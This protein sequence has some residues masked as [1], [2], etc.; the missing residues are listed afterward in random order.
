MGINFRFNAK[1]LYRSFLLPAT[2]LTVAFAALLLGG[3]QRPSVERA[4]S[5]QSPSARDKIALPKAAQ[6]PEAEIYVDEAMR[7]PPMAVIG[8]TIQN[9]AAR[10]LDDL[11]VEI[12]LTRRKD[13]S[14]EMRAVPVVPASLEPGDKGR[15]SISI[16]SEEWGSSR[17]VRLRSSASAAE[18][19][20]KTLPGARRAP[21]RIA[22]PPTKIIQEPRPRP[23]SSNDGFLNSPD[24]P[25]PVP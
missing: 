13:G 15:Y 18:V 10:K 20:Y 4:R 7:R 3:C 14:K 23:K 24:D 11:T 21:E 16:P 2:T 8:G 25:I 12:E 1:H 9:V 6:T 17:V 19:A 5:E 22:A